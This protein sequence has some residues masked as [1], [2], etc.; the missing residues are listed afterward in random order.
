MYK[1]LVVIFNSVVLRKIQN[2]VFLN[3]LNPTG[4]VMHQ[5]V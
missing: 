2:K 4:H 5:Q 3:L 1:Y